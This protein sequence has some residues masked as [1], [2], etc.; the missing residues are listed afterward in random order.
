MAEAVTFLR[1]KITGG[2]EKKPQNDPAFGSW[3][4]HRHSSFPLA[5]TLELSWVLS[6]FGAA[7]GKN[8]RAFFCICKDCKSELSGRG[9]GVEMSQSNGQ[10]A[11]ELYCVLIGIWNGLVLY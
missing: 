5:L 7:N 1:H 2:N 9:L 6:C 4:W 10:S 8:C 11:A 3:H